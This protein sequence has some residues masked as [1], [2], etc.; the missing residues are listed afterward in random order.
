MK[1][2]ITW[3]MS[4]YTWP[5][6]LPTRLLLIFTSGISPQLSQVYFGLLVERHADTYFYTNDIVTCSCAGARATFNRKQSNDSKCTKL[7][8]MRNT[9]LFDKQPV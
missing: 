8:V 6:S 4:A 2:M 3:I 5:W 7:W 1:K 9:L